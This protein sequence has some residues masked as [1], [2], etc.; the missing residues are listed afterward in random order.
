MT[1]PATSPRNTIIGFALAIGGA[2]LFSSKGILIK[3]AFEEGLSTETVML[4]RMGLSLPFFLYIGFKTAPPKTSETA[5]HGNR[6]KMIYCGI[7]GYYLATWLSFHSLHFISVQLERIILF[8]YPALVVAGSALVS[9]KLPS[10][11][12]V[13]AVLLAYAGV[14]VL[15]G[16]EFATA[17]TSGSTTGDVAYGSILVGQSALF[18]AS[19]VL[20]SKGLIQTYGSAFFTATTMSISTVAIIIHSIIVAA[21]TA[22]FATLL[23]A[24][25]S[26]AILGAIAI[27]GTVIP[28][29][30]LS[31]AVARIGPE[32]MA[33][34][35]T[36]GPVAT[37]LIAV[38]ALGELFTAYHAV[39][40][41]L[42]SSGV[43]LITAK[44]KPA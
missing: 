27:V 18:F 22:D 9:R 10:K 36:A 5:S 40:I 34:S 16:F 24:A 42:C 28:T 13:F 29:F 20:M 26:Y 7:F 3:F 4:Y 25:S 1:A 33:I 37:S 43:L 19:Y 21:A 31:E 30:M 15:F 35:G 41:A 14:A 8:S 11:R 23:P 12:M 32:R 2:I 17:G 44:S 39:S 6:L 38:I